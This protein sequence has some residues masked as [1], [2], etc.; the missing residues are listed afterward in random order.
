MALGLNTTASGLASIAFGNGTTA[1]GGSSVALGTN[2]YAGGE[3][4]TA[5][6]TSTVATGF[7]S[8][9]LGYSASTNGKSGAFVY[10]DYS[11]TGNYVMPTTN[12]QF[13]VRAQR[14]WFGTN[15][16]VT[17]TAG[18]YIETSTGAY[19]SYGGT[20]ANSSDVARK[21][22]FATVEGDAVL[23]KVAALS[24]QSWNYKD[25]ESAVRHIGPTAQDFHAAFGLGDTDKAIATVDADGVSLAAIQAL[26]KRSREQ[27]REI[28]GLKQANNELRERMDRQQAETAAE[29]EALRRNMAELLGARR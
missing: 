17:A 16:N 15:N 2:A 19:L 27:A 11:P 25:E 4:A 24:I 14:F 12:N 6:G 8:T 7:A 26:E 3:S 18:R 13:V 22:N 9:A 23:A 29:L 5:I 1:S 20:W 10:G 21:A 28:D